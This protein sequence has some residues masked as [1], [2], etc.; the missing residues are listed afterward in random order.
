MTVILP[1]AL[2]RYFEAQ[3]RH[4]IDALLAYFAPDAVVRDEGEDIAGLAA[5]RA[6][7]ESTGARYRVTASPKCVEKKDGRTVVVASVAG[8]FPGSPAD[9]TYRF[10]LAGDGSIAALAIG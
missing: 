1:A 9:L 2:S 4:D 6:W 8:N 3:N 10:K 7:K 5:I